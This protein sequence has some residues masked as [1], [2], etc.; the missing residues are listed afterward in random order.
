MAA[1]EVKSLFNANSELDLV[2]LESGQV[3][4]LVIPASSESSSV[5][6]VASELKFLVKANSDL[7]L[8]DMKSGINFLVIESGS[9]TMVAFEVKSLACEA[10]EVTSVFKG[11]LISKELFGVIVSTK[12]PSKF[13]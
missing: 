2:N 7:K 12:K 9:I 5:N 13:V 11:Q 3:N 1:S 8:V 4:F 10:S 6:K